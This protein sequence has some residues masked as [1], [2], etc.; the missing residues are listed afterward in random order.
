MSVPTTDVT[1]PGFRTTVV[2]IIGY[3]PFLAVLPMPSRTTVFVAV[4]A[5]RYLPFS[6][7]SR[8]SSGSP[9]APSGV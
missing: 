5:M 8:F 4:L 7:T 6:E 9:P 1:V 2:V 3:A